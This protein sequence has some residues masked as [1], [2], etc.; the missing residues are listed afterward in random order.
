MNKEFMKSSGLKEKLLKENKLLITSLKEAIKTLNDDISKYFEII[1]CD[2]KLQDPWILI[3]KVD[4]SFLIFS[5]LYYK[6]RNVYFDQTHDLYPEKT[7]V[8][9]LENFE[10]YSVDELMSYKTETLNDLDLKKVI[11][12]VA[13]F[14]VLYRDDCLNAVYSHVDYFPGRKNRIKMLSAH[15]NILESFIRRL[16]ANEF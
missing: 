5:D 10:T 2:D 9:Y 4:A 14:Y 11:D 16:R 15:K 3:K 13:E 7:E 8:K 1:F 12:R 6:I